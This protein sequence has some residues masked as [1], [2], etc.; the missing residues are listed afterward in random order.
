M[1][2]LQR[3]TSSRCD[4]ASSAFLSARCCCCAQDFFGCTSEGFAA[5]DSNSCLERNTPFAT[6]SVGQV[7]AD[8]SVL[9]V[10]KGKASLKDYDV[11]LPL[12]VLR[13]LHVHAAV[14]VSDSPVFL[15]RC[16]IHSIGRGLEVTPSL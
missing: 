12:P 9:F 16:L 10:P 8:A 7:D 13:L 15:E 4:W 2:R 14:T 5:S 1:K 11:S 6:N 3:K